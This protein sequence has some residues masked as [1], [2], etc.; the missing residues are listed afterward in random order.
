MKRLTRLIEVTLI[1]AFVSAC[2]RS[3]PSPTS[4]PTMRPSPQASELRPTPTQL[5]PTPSGRPTSTGLSIGDTWT[6]PTDNAVMVYVPGGEFDMGTTKDQM[7]YSLQLCEEDDARTFG[8][9]ARCFSTE[10]ADETPA[11][12][13]ILD[14]FWIDRTEV[15]NKQFER[16][17]RAGSCTQPTQ[18]GSYTRTSYFGDSAYDDYPV[19]WVR[20]D[21]ATDY[22]QWVGARLPTEAEWEYAARG[23]ESRMFPWG[24][25]FDG[26]RLDY[27]DASCELG[28]A[29]PSTDDGYPDTAPVG[30]YPAGMSWCG[31]LDMAGNVREWVSDW[32]GPYQAGQQVNPGGPTSGQL[33]VSRGGSWFD[34]PSNVRSVKR[35]QNTPDFSAYK[36][37][38][39]CVQD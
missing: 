29:D 38:I 1:C 31:A 23:P 7:K 35:G 22:C 19:M 12:V 37:G 15:T 6:R 4:Y 32:Y 39:R 28:I 8:E 20:W 9:D 13:V 27:C 18:K 36:L 5:L 11:H 34:P 30:S 26:T 2:A 16:C 17:V 10:Y 33:L 24:N 21:Q 3:K 14:G 25:S